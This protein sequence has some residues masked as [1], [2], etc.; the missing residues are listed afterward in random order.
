[1]LGAPPLLETVLEDHCCTPDIADVLS[2]LWPGLKDL[3]RAGNRLRPLPAVPGHQLAHS[4]ARHGETNQA[5]K[6]GHVVDSQ[7]SNSGREEEH[8]GEVAD[9]SVRP[10]KAGLGQLSENVVLDVGSCTPEDSTTSNGA[11]GLCISKVQSQSCQGPTARLESRKR[12][13]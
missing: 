13:R 7:P 6:P 11:R 10:C 9:V 1:M 8:A 2:L 4:L 3:A 12:S 5:M